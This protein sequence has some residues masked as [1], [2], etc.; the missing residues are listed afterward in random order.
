M[1]KSGQTLITRELAINYG[2]TDIDGKQPPSPTGM[3]GHPAQANP[4]VGGATAVAP[5]LRNRKPLAPTPSQT[6][7]ATVD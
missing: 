7:D 5:W 2:F 1:D 3:L 4:A 6:N